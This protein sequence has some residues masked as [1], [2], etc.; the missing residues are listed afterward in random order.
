MV[1]IKGKLREIIDIVSYF[2]ASTMSFTSKNYNDC[3]LIAFKYI[4]QCPSTIH[5]IQQQ[6]NIFFL[7]QR[8]QDEKL[9]H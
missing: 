9:K 2:N 4:H 3:V 5:T 6:F 7:M 8:L 1:M